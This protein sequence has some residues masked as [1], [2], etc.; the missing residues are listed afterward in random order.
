MSYH[1]FWRP[2]NI[3]LKFGGWEN[4]E[5]VIPTIVKS[6]CQLFVFFFIEGFF[7]VLFSF[8]SSLSAS[9]DVIQHEGGRCIKVARISF[10]NQTPCLGKPPCILYCVRYMVYGESLLKYIP[11]IEQ[12]AVYSKCSDHIKVR[13]GKTCQPCQA[14]GANFFQPG[15]IFLAKNAKYCA[16]KS[17]L[18]SVLAPITMLI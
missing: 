8:S 16:T 5:H 1:A 6:H 10:W 12:C 2:L 17:I 7:V 9:T 18:L 13:V 11:D 15:L 3:N 14:A 4:I